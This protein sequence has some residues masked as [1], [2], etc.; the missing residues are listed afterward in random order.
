MEFR[1]AHLDDLQ[2]LIELRK[3]QQVAQGIEPKT[4][5]DAD[6]E[7]FFQKKLKEGSMVQWLAED[8]GEIVACGAVIFYEFPPSYVNKSG[9]KAYITNVYTKEEYR[10][11]GIAKEL[12]GKLVDEVKKAGISNIW[13]GASEMGKPLYEKFGFQEVDE[14]MELHL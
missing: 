12:M 4:D 7:K 11:Q 14:W 8:E 5:I 13:L 3:Q 10:G 1:K 2:H 9:K 6:L